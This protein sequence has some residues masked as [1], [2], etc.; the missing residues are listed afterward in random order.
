MGSSALH[1]EPFSKQQTFARATIV[2]ISKTNK[3]DQ[4]II[5]ITDMNRHVSGDYHAVLEI[6]HRTR[7][8]RALRCLNATLTAPGDDLNYGR[9]AHY[10]VRWSEQAFPASAAA[11]EGLSTQRL[12]TSPLAAGEPEALELDGLLGGTRYYVGLVAVDRHGNRLPLST[13][14]TAVTPAGIPPMVS[15]L[16]AQRSVD[17]W[18]TTLSFTAPRDRRGDAPA[19][20]DIRMSERPIESRNFGL[21]TPLTTIAPIEPGQLVS[22]D[23]QHSD[24]NQAYFFAMKVVGQEGET[25]RLSNLRFS[26]PVRPTDTTEPAQSNLVGELLAPLVTDPPLKLSTRQ[27]TMLLQS[28][29]P[30]MRP[31]LAFTVVVDGESVTLEAEREHPRILNQFIMTLSL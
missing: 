6:Y 15:D 11:F 7:W 23:I 1:R 8:S 10:E 19:A 18:G 13:L 27:G 30:T 5:D 3:F 12:Y 29:M 28:E 2:R 25:S 20:Y 21:A 31:S 26:L 14:T 24:P 22:V 17:D 9:A 4:I 16:S